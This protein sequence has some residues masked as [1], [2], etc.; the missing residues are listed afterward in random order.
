M[1]QGKRLCTLSPDWQVPLFPLIRFVLRLVITAQSTDI[2]QDWRT[3]IG[4][5]ALVV[6]GEFFKASC[7]TQEDILDF[8]QW[9]TDFKTNFNF[10]YGSPDA[11]QVRIFYIFRES[12]C[13]NNLFLG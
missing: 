1:G 3:S 6:L 12:E 13:I 2:L 11:P 7:D 8:V 4:H 5:N 10:I 9:A